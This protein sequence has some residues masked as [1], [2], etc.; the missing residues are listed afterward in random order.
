M[1]KKISKFFF[2]LDISDFKNMLRNDTILELQNIFEMHHFLKTFRKSTLK[3]SC[4]LKNISNQEII[5]GN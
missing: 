3:L 2:H 5:H 4:A 1:Y